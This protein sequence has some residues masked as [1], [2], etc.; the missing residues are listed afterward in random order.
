[1]QYRVREQNELKQS[2]IE[3]LGVIP[4]KWNTKK[5]KHVFKLIKTKSYDKN[6]RVL[7]LTQKGIKTRDV[8]S[9][10]GQI[11]S[12]YEG[13]ISLEKNDFVLNPMDLISGYVD[14]VEYSGVISPA[15]ISFKNKI[16]TK[17]NFDYYKFYFQLHYNHNYLFPFGEGVSIVHRWTLKNETFLNL[18]IIYPPTK[19]Q[20][21]IANFLDENSKVFD[22]AISKKEELISSLELAKQSLLSEV[23]TGKLKVIKKDGE[24]Q[25]VKRQKEELKLSK[26][27]S[28]GNIP[29]DWDVKKLK[30][31]AYKITSGSTPLGGAATYVDKGIPF[32]RSQNIHFNGL[33]LEKVSFISNKVHENMKRSQLKG[34]DILINITGA[35]IGRVTYIPEDFKEGNVNQ[36][37]CIVRINHKEAYY[38]YISM[39][40]S[41]NYGQNQVFVNQ[42]GTSRE[43]LTFEDLGNFSIIFPSIDEQIDISKYLDEKIK[44][45][46]N[47]I[48]KTKQSIMKLKQAK[49]SL[50]SEAVT[51]KI[52]IL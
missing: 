40:L 2:G 20:Q 11:A 33:S 16:N 25:T 39:F 45:F 31:F 48:E 18:P 34:K 8:L 9:N 41:T 38:K 14:K 29:K 22:N 26:V 37:V 10:E 27:D 7:S 32:L 5:I 15:Y 4:N 36:H 47:T 6:P 1:M 13:Y 43:G 19:E 17:I 24:F 52:E 28:L 44:T 50:I 3:W 49:E 12:T 21:K 51:G 23:V 35:S 42:V 46:D 30:Y